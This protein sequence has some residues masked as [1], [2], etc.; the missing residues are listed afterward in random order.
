[1]IPVLIVI[2]CQVADP[3]EVVA[4]VKHID[5]PTVP[6][7]AGDIRVV[8]GANVAEVVAFMDEP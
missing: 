6:H 5:P 4:I 2:S 8:A 1:M 7:F 3:E